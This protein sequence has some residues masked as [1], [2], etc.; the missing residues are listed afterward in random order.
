MK[1][2][3]I[4]VGTIILRWNGMSNDKGVVFSTTKKEAT[5][6]WK[7][8][9]E[10]V[11]KDTLKWQ[12]KYSYDE[13]KW[14]WNWKASALDVEETL[15]EKTEGNWIKTYRAGELVSMKLTEEAHKQMG[16]R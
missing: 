3:K 14:I 16:Q 12:K 1:A 6:M 10:E 15:D 7:G 5:V 13:N 2:T 9:K 8:I 11:E 4:K